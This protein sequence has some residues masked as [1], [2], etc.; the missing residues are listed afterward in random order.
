MVDMTQ[1]T[2]GLWRPGQEQHIS[3]SHLLCAFSRTD[4]A[5]NQAWPINTTILLKL[6]AMPLPKKF[7]EEQ[8]LAVCQ[9]AAMSFYYLM[10]PVEYAES[11]SNAIDHDTL[12][13]PFRLRHASFLLTHGKYHAAHLVTPTASVDV[14]T[15]SSPPGTWLR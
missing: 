1:A 9:L 2:I 5:P 11:R 4:P 13:K 3:I 15:L 10:Q 6:L 7:S 8:W 12:G 14:M